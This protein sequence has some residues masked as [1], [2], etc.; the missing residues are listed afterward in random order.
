MIY[1]FFF[2]VYFWCKRRSLET[3]KRFFFRREFERN[4]RLFQHTPLGTYPP[5][6]KPL[7]TR[8][9]TPGFR[10]HSWLETGD[11]RCRGGLRRVCCNYLGVIHH[12][13]NPP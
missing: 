8:P 7:P 3:S 4:L 2:A 12:L 13:E 5:E 9:N 11:C 1:S 6:Q 10:I